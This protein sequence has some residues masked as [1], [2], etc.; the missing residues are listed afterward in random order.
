[1][2]VVVV[3]VRVR[4]KLRNRVRVRVRVGLVLGGQGRI[5]GVRGQGDKQDKTKR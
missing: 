4:T 1:M 2:V 3:L 5:L